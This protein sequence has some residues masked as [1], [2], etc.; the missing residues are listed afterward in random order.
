MSMCAKEELPPGV[1]SSWEECKCLNRLRT[2]TGR[3]K[4][5][6]KK[7][8]FLKNGDATCECGTEPQFMEHLLRCP[9][10][11]HDCKAEALQN[12]MNVLG[13]VFSFG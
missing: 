12:S 1:D 6:L 3:C 9:L 13:T 7:W 11:E 10:L 8:G 5:S 4:I 2:G